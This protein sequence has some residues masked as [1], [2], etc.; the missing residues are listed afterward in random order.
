MGSVESAD[1]HMGKFSPA[2]CGLSQT[3]SVTLAAEYKT[4]FFQQL[5]KT[6]NHWRKRRQPQF[7][8]FP[9]GSFEAIQRAQQWH[10]CTS[11]SFS[12][13][14]FRFVRPIFHFAS[15]NCEKQTQMF[16]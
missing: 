7:F 4:A 16:R 14:R 6:L 9:T 1:K 5:V 2:T 8:E 12:S 10:R 11:N 3:T 15:C 13:K